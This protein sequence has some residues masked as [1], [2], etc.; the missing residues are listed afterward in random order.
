MLSHVAT[1]GSVSER[2][3][4]RKYATPRPL[5]KNMKPRKRPMQK[6]HVKQQTMIRIANT[7]SATPRKREETAVVTIVPPTKDMI[8]PYVWLNATK[9]SMPAAR[10]RWDGGWWEGGV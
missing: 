3:P 1:R 10:R 9:R 2:R 8:A 7:S 6:N 5:R 4:R